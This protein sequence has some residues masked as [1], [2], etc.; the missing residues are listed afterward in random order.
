MACRAASFAC[1]FPGYCRL[2][3]KVLFEYTL[4]ASGVLVA[5]TVAVGLG[6]GADVGVLTGRPD[7]RVGVASWLMATRCPRKAF[8]PTMIRT[9]TAASSAK[10]AH[11]VYSQRGTMEAGASRRAAAAETGSGIL[12]PW[13]LVMAMG[14]S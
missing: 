4:R 9:A 2:K 3:P 6:V 8:Q 1:Q 10:P 11:P 5:G 12:R 7:D 14:V 13:C